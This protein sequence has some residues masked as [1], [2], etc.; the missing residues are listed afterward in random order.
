VGSGLGLWL[1]GGAVDALAGIVRYL[2]MMELTITE[3]M[4]LFFGVLFIMATPAVMF[5]LRIKKLVW[6]NS[7]K[8]VELASDLR[9]T[10]AAAL[11]TYGTLSLAIRAIFTVL[12]RDSGSLTEGLLDTLLFAASALGAVIAGGLGPLARSLRRKANQ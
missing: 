1:V 6:P 4:L 12:L 2:H 10:A 3:S 8:A 7:V 5:V 11:V 9:R